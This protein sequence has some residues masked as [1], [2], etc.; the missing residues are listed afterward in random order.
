MVG[1]HTVSLE[2]RSPIGCFTSATFPNLIEIE[3]SPTAGFIMTPEVINSLNPTAT[4][5]DLSSGGAAGWYWDFCGEGRS[6]NQSPTYTF[7]DTGICDITQVV[8]HPNGCTDTLVKTIDIES[9][10]QFFLP[11]AFT[12]NYDG[13]NEVYKPEGI[14]LGA[15][16][17]SLTIWSRWGEEVFA[18]TDPEGGWNGRKNNTGQEMPVGVYLCVL[19]YKDARKRPNE[20]R[21][22]V[23]LLR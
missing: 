12:P 8:F 18:T 7:R 6:F 17:Y 9:I 15:S 16:S 13:K 21:E 10:V 19:K 23:T 3:A 20:M 11:N 22:F 4:F 1:I 5:T 2:I 14:S